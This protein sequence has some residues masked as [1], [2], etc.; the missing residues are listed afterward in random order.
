MADGGFSAQAMSNGV[1]FC[2]NS[3][4]NQSGILAYQMAVGSSLVEL[5]VRQDNDCDPHF[6]QNT[7]AAGRTMA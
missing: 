4:L 7:S 5:R 6:V 2:L 3:M 1:Q